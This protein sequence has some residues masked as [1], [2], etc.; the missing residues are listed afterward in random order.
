MPAGRFFSP[1]FT[2]IMPPQIHA[3]ISRN[4]ISKKV[5]SILPPYNYIKNR[6]EQPPKISDNVLRVFL[7]TTI[8]VTVHIRGIRPYADDNFSIHLKYRGN[9]VLHLD[10]LAFDDFHHVSMLDVT[11]LV[12]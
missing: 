2:P 11:A 10:V 4:A 12:D 5:N 1:R 6:A 8:F 3:E 9:V 7:F